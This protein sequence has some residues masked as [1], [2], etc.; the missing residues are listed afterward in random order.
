MDLMYIDCFDKFTNVQTIFHTSFKQ[1][2]LLG[3]MP[4]LSKLGVFDIKIQI[5][6]CANKIIMMIMDPI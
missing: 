1:T 2:S 5:S 6:L 3:E 4:L